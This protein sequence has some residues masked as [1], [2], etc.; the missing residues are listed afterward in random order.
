MTIEKFRWDFHLFD[1]EGGGDA[2][3][4]TASS[5]ESKQDGQKIQYGKSSEGEGQTPSQVGSDNGSGADDLSAEW[6]AL[7][8]K[9]GKF[10]DMLGQRVSS[11]IQDRFK[12]QADLQAQVNGIA[13]DL[14]PLFMNYGLKPGDFEGLKAAVQSD[15]TFYKSGA[16]KA[17]LD[18]EQYKEM[19][20]LKADS[21][22]LSQITQEFQ[23]EQERQ[24]KYAEWEADTVELQQAFPA[25]DLALEI[26]NNDMFAQLL[27]SGVDVRTAFLST[28][29]DEILN[30]ANAYAQKA[31][32]ANVVS[33]IQQRAARPMEGALNHAPAIQR[34]SDPSSLSN[35]DLDEINRRVANGETVSF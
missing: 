8:G 27:D 20:K 15:D 12:N 21:E 23:H 4:A 33:T 17:G 5:S 2:G 19:L 34:K 24:A 32:T 22:R 35:E 3:E 7:T 31:A 29:V 26:E 28:H 6:E 14:S 25:F 16:E 18:V 30:G 13:D 11:A 1:G 9:G 10:H